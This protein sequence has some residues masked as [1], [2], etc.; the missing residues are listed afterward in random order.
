MVVLVSSSSACSW[1]YLGLVV[2]VKSEL[3]RRVPCG[4]DDRQHVV[5]SMVFH[6]A[7]LA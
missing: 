3:R 6:D 1:D 2:A 4:N 5:R 7:S